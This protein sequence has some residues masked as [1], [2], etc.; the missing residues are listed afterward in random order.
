MSLVYLALAVSVHAQ[1]SLRRDVRINDDAGIAQQTAPSIATQANGSSIV[2]WLDRRSGIH[3]IYTQ[4]LNE[5]WAKESVNQVLAS[6]SSD[7]ERFEFSISSSITGAYSVCWK[8]FRNGSFPFGA[9]IYQRMLDSAGSPVGVESVMTSAQTDSLFETPDIANHTD[10]SGITVWTQHHNN[11]WDVFGLQF[12]P[13]GN[14][15][16]EPFIVNRDLALAQQ[17]APRVSISSL[18]W[19]VVCWYDNRYGN[20]DVFF[21]LYDSTGAPLGENIRA[22]DGS[23]KDLSARQA[24]P[25]IACDGSGRFTICWVDWR[26]GIYPQNPDIFIR[27]FSASGVPLNDAERIATDEMLAPQKEPSLATDRLGNVMVVWA[28]S[29]YGGWDIYARLIDHRGK[30][31]DTAFLVNTDTLGRQVQPD[32]SMDGY[33][34]RIVWSDMRSGNFDIYGT[35]IEYNDPALIIDPSEIRFSMHTSGPAPRAQTV[36]VLNAGLGQLIYEIVETTSW[37]SVSKS[38]G[39]APDSIEIS[40]NQSAM[41][42]GSYYGEALIIDHTNFDSSNVLRVRLS[43]TTSEI[44]LPYDTLII[45]APTQL[46]TPP[47]A[48]VVPLN[49][50]SGTLNWTAT[51]N[52]SWLSLSRYSGLAG[53]SLTITFTVT[54]L[55]VAEHLGAIVFEDSLASNS[56]ETLFVALRYFSDIPY[57][58]LDIDTLAALITTDVSLD[59]ALRVRNFGGGSLSW[60][61]S[62]SDSWIGLRN[63]SGITNDSL[64]LTIDASSLTPGEYSGWVIVSDI[65]A[66]NN[67]LVLPITLSVLTRDTLVFADASAN[68]GESF[69]LT[70]SIMA[71]DNPTSVNLSLIIDS[72]YLY[73][74]S[75]T[76]IDSLNADHTLETIY[77]SQAGALQISYAANSLLAPK[78]VTG[79]YEL[80]TIHLR[81]ANRE[82]SF[83]TDQLLDNP[84]STYFAYLGGSAI[85]APIQH[86]I[87]TVGLTTDVVDEPS[88]PALPATLVVGQNY[89]NPFNA[90][91]LFSV[92]FPSVAEVRVRVFNILG[93][94]IRTLFVGQVQAGVRVFGWNGKLDSGREAPS[95]MY[96]YQVQVG[97]EAIVRK[98]MLIK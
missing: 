88:N 91:M 47:P 24:F 38:V 87:I 82:F 58:G 14:A 4:R 92:S 98:A 53:D 10:G 79:E 59:T 43:V 27:R 85:S 8:D 20:D 66:A 23:E 15:I 17:H 21:Q 52:I 76:L 26:N 63:S 12:D 31:V 41:P 54:G 93:Q 84:D 73:Y 36:S 94:K 50:G 77:D 34:A 11:N 64:T 78:I 3:D 18:G 86:G 33:D 67:P 56:P 81:S 32:V 16:G 28:D 60:T 96:L 46:G 25:A 69:E 2:G 9:D 6:D 40:V 95:G 30:Y 74:D 44:S 1:D 42:V 5:F 48:L 62:A 29:S 68:P 65:G 45:E 19:F 51:E 49:A 83:A 70:L 35:Q 39:L 7:A 97:D 71:N 57:L 80:F 55:S 90:E 22:N 72:L 13:F 89:P 61:A 37:L 75:T